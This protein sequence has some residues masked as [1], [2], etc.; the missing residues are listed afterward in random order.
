MDGSVAVFPDR[1]R[2][3]PNEYRSDFRGGNENAVPTDGG[4]GAIRNRP[5]DAYSVIRNASFGT[6]F[7]K[8]SPGV[9]ALKSGF[10]KSA[11]S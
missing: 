5:C 7:V 2:R 11:E 4:H 1:F 10:R 3:D 6:P 9:N 8:A